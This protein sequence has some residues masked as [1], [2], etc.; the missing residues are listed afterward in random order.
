M[1]TINIYFYQFCKFIT[2]YCYYV[3]AI[4]GKP[5]VG[6]HYSVVHMYAL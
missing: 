4:Q 5:K 6:I 1:E 3:T 2:H